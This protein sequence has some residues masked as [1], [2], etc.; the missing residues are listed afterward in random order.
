MKFFE[1]PVVKIINNLVIIGTCA[2]TA[3]LLL[4]NLPW[5][6]PQLG[7]GETVMPAFY[8]IVFAAIA[9]AVYSSSKIK[10]VRILSIG[11]SM[12]FI[13]LIAGMWLRA[14]A[15]GK[16]SPADFFGTAGMLGEYF[17]NLHRF[18]LPINDY[19]EFY[20]FWWFSWSIMIGQFTARFV[21]GIKTWQL[22]IA[23]LVVPS[24]AIGVWFSV[25]FH[26]HAEG[27][28][29]AA[30]TNLAMISVGVLMVVNSLDS[31]IRLYTDNLNLTARRMG[32]MNY[33]IVNFGIMVMLTMLFQL[34][35]LRIQWVGALVIALYFTCFAYIL[36]NK[37]A[38]V[39][40]IKSSPRENILDFR[41]IELA[42]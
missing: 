13:A 37:R 7:D 5:Y 31:L 29:I 1:I 30:L 20:L 42:G 35:F 21:S 41:K 4:V 22:L 32:R 15:M 33:V 10:Y 11:S 2:F 28:K 14:F 38:E 17:T 34:D 27:L 39:A 9:L 3:Y 40:A 8:V 23:M 26:Y 19:H 16:G 24:I 18:A 25:L 36:V 12:L 6:L